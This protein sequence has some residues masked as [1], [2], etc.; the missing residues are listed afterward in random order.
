M[1]TV[2]AIVPAGS[3]LQAELFVPSRAAGF[4]RPGQEVRL[5]YDAFPH[6]TFG[7]SIGRVAEISRT[8]LAPSEVTS[9]LELREPVFRVRVNLDRE[10]VE[11]Y[12]EHIPLQAGMSLRADLII[13]R[14]TLIEWLLDPVYAAARR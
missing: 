4:I 14:R 3:R 5:M 6:Q 1:E 13:D 2:A 8:V 11:A 10:E 9:G 12:G 7:A